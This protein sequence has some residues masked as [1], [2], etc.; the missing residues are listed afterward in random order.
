MSIA[1]RYSVVQIL[2]LHHLACICQG[3]WKIRLRWQRGSERA[4][5]YDDELV[6]TVL[7]VPVYTYIRRMVTLP[8][9]IQER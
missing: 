1:R 8:S 2:I 7:T 4:G 5:K 9:A 3:K 6:K